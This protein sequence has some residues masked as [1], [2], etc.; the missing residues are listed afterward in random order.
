MD[1]ETKNRFR[2]RWDDLWHRIS[3]HPEKTGAFEELA[4]AYDAPHRY[5]HTFT[6]IKKCLMDL[7]SVKIPSKSCDNVELALW[8]H[9][10]VYDPMSSDNEMK[11]AA[12][13]KRTIE[14]NGIDGKLPD[15]VYTLV[16]ATAHDHIP[17]HENEMLIVDIDLS[18]LGAE[19]DEYEDYSGKIRQE[20]ARVSWPLYRTGRIEILERFL[21]KDS[22]YFTDFFQKKFEVKAGSN[23]LKEI[24]WLKNEEP[25]QVGFPKGDVLEVVS[26]MPTSSD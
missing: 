9:D 2:K 19:P 17:E 21:K 24:E 25:N 6:H 1:A 13:A 4:A 5:Y 8:F 20:Y 3:G 12:W 26:M 22:I 11:S 7:D 14:A 18:I 15:A 16:M 10:A 23:I